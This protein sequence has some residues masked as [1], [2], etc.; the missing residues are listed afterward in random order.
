MKTAVS[1]LTIYQGASFEKVLLLKDKNNH[2]YD[3]T[4]YTADLQIREVIEDVSALVNLTTENGGITIVGAEGKIT[5]Y[6]SST[7]TASLDFIQGVYDLKIDS[8]A[9]VYRILEGIV[10]LDKQVTR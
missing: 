6:I 10:Y 9:R 3:L 2:P 8:G 5:L 7:A 4:G 1:D